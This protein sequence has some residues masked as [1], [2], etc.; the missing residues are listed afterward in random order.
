MRIRICN[1]LLVINSNCWRIS[2][3]FRDIDTLSY[4][5]ACF[6]HPTIVWRRQWRNALHN[7]HN[8]YIAEKYILVGYNFVG[9]ITGLSLFI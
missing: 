8:L 6:P 4:K 3:S 7:Q 2:Y 9:D 1:F 5:I